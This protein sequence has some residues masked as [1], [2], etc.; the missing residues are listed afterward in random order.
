M[1]NNAVIFVKASYWIVYNETLTNK[2]FKF[3]IVNL[4]EH[5]YRIACQ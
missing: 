2:L 5:C 3:S 1:K 4:G